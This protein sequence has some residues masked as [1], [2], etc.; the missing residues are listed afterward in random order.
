MTSEQLRAARAMAR[1]EQSALAE[2]AGVSVETIKR[3]E[4]MD[5]DLSATRVATLKALQSALEAAG[6]IF[7]PGNGDGPG[8][9]SR[10]PLPTPHELSEKI[11]NLHETLPVVDEKAKPSPHKAMKQLEH[12]HVKN[13]IA[14]AKEKHTKMTTK[15]PKPKS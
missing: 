2:A 10:K 9:R 11:A 6:V 1:M 15:S 14:K 3:L 13:E 12:A 8:V 7:V 5:G 4:K